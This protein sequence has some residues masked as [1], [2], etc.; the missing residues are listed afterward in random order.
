[1]GEL[2][3]ERIALSIEQHLKNYSENAYATDRHEILWHAWKHNKQ[4]LRQIQEWILPS[5]PTYSRHDESHALSVLHNIEMLL[6]ENQIRQ[7]SA[8]DCF[9][10]LHVVYIHDIGM[11]ITYQERNELMQNRKFIQFLNDKRGSSDG[12]IRKYAE[13]L[14]KYCKE[15]P[16][17]N[18]QEEVLKIKLDVY[19]AIIYLVSEF[20]R[21]DHGKSSERVLNEWIDKPDKLGIGFSTYGIPSRFYHTIGSCASVHTSYDFNDVME[22][23]K[24]DSGFACDYMHPRFAAVLLQL[25]DALDL[26]NDRF[27]PLVKEFMGLLPDVSE[28]HLQKHRSIRR[29]RISPDKITI[30]ANCE[31]ADVLRLV[32]RECEGI[33]DILQNATFNWSAICPEEVTARLPTLEPIRLFLNGDEVKDN[34]VNAKFEIQQKKA[35]ELLQGSNVYEKDKLVFLREILQNAIDASKMQYW[36]DWKGSRWYIPQDKKQKEKTEKDIQYIGKRISPLGYPIEIELHLAIREKY[37]KKYRCLDETTDADLFNAKEIEHGVLVKVIDY[38]TG[39]TRKDVQLIA[40]VGTG[41]EQRKETM[42]DMPSWLS[43]TAEFG[44]GL[45]SVFLVTENFVA[46]THTRSGEKNKIEFHATGRKGDGFINVVPVKDKNKEQKFGTIFEVFVPNSTKAEHQRSIKSW[47]GEDPFRIDYEINRPKRHSRE[48]IVQLALYLDSLVGEKLFPIKLRLYDIE[49]EG[50]KIFQR[51]ISQE[52]Q[53]VECELYMA[54]EKQNESPELT[55]HMEKN[56][57][58]SISWLYHIADDE[59]MI[60]GDAGNKYKYAF[61]LKE[62]KLY[63][64][65]SENNVCACLGGERIQTVRTKSKLLEIDEQF[66]K[67]KIYYKGIYAT[68]VDWKM[69]GYLLEYIDIKG[70]LDRKYLSLNRGYFTEEGERYIKEEIYT[71]VLAAAH[72]ALDELEKQQRKIGNFSEEKY[73]ESREKG[74]EKVYIKEIFDNKKGPIKKIFDYLNQLMDNSNNPKEIQNKILTTVGMASFVQIRNGSDYPGMPKHEECLMWNVLLSELSDIIKAKQGLPKNISWLDSTFFHINIICSDQI[75]NKKAPLW[76]EMNAAEIAHC[77]NKFAIVSKRKSIHSAWEEYLILLKDEPPLKEWIMELK[78]SWDRAKRKNLIKDLDNWGAGIIEAIPESIPYKSGTNYY[79]HHL[80]LN[81]ILGNVPSI[82]LF[83]NAANT[84]RVNVIDFEHTDSMYFDT[85]TKWSIYQRMR[86]CYQRQ[87]IERFSTIAPTGYCQMA[88][89]Y[90]N[91][92]IYFVKRGKFTVN[93]QRDMIVP[94][95]GSD[96]DW[97]F[98]NIENSTISGKEM[99][100]KNLMER[101]GFDCKG[102]EH[103]RQNINK[104]LVH[105]I[106]QQG[107]V[108]VSEE[109]LMRL[110]Q[111]YILDTVDMLEKIE[112]IKSEKSNKNGRTVQRKRHWRLRRK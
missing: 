76:K 90:K 27:H 85:W 10:I 39:I 60:F 33:R 87:G 82:A 61:N 16:L 38:G 70:K 96:L 67:T 97:I 109:Q 6:G 5:Y 46:L 42:E 72:N 13:L 102:Q 110:L 77:E 83:S 41:Y 22:L 65:H 101:C 2:N 66:V 19:Y 37:G 48:L 86:E 53:N 36:E 95:T 47:C 44:I 112:N 31:S 108:Q 74:E 56:E 28:L 80:I 103:E 68:S 71:S 12:L 32:N 14:L 54:G 1:M 79:N 69:D 45:Q 52:I 49:D 9:L 63:L 43:P 4:W 21:G 92:S 40:D 34:L 104:K 25:G 64:W 15:M 59:N 29:L 94:F 23:S 26:D 88:V 93:G 20:K 84:I 78:T 51:M 111:L 106:M 107:W 105:Y 30:E 73:K 62:I 75:K 100:T 89:T 58:Q 98:S 81:W 55:S 3:E 57:Q 17:A 24:T 91:P 7:L 99:W 18:S 50:I 11:C 35:F 8:S